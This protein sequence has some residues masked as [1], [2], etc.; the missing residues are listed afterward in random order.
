MENHDPGFKVHA[1][2][3][4][5]IYLNYDCELSLPN[6][7]QRLINN[8]S[9]V[10]QGCQ[11]FELGATPVQERSIRIKGLE[12]LVSILKCMVEWSTDSQVDDN[13]DL[14]DGAPTIS[15]K[16]STEENENVVEP[17]DLQ[18]QKT[19]GNQSSLNSSKAIDNAEEFESLKQKK[20]TKEKGIQL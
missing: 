8:L 5:D 12:C 2:T 6:I 16:G 9:K 11:A 4:V 17:G 18:S 13:F 19:G 7:F 14:V 15:R 10:A 1:Q 3:V 20:E